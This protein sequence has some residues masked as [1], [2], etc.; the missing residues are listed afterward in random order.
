MKNTTD[1]RTLFRQ[2]IIKMNLIRNA[3]KINK[4]H[5]NKIKSQILKFC[6]LLK[7]PGLCKIFLYYIVNHAKFSEAPLS[8]N[9]IVL[10]P[11]L[12]L[13]SSS[14]VLDVN[15]KLHKALCSVRHF[16]LIII[17]LTFYFNI[18]ELNPRNTND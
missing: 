16:N 2:S 3:Y 14:S 13:T 8:L 5:R 6:L 18:N 4:T 1:I 7:S 9:Q 15:S 12:S 11:H 10:F 17:C